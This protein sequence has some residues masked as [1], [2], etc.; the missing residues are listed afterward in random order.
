MLITSTYTPVMYTQFNGTRTYS[1]Y[2][3]TVHQLKPTLQLVIQL[4]GLNFYASDL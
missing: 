4:T 2:V 1:R 3:Y